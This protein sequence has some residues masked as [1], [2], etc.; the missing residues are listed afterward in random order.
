M[1]LATILGLIIGTI[2]IIILYN[3]IREKHEEEENK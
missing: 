2:L 3:I 1:D